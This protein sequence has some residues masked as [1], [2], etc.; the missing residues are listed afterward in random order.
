MLAR[1]GRADEAAAALADA[2]A[3]H[4]AKGNVVG[5]RQARALLA[6]EATPRPA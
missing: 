6:A 3:L 1:A 4:E 5:A 2:V